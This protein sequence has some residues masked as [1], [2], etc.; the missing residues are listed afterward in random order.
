MYR[1][2]SS[3]FARG[4]VLTAF[5]LVS[6]A[7]P[8]QMR[9]EPVDEYRAN[10]EF[11]QLM[12][13]QNRPMASTDGRQAMSTMLSELMSSSN[14]NARNHAVGAVAP[15]VVQVPMKAFTRLWNRV[16]KQAAHATPKRQSPAV[17]LGES[18]YTG[19]ANPTTGILELT[20]RLGVTLSRPDQ[21]KAVPLVGEDVVL[22]RATVA[23]KPIPVSAAHGYQVWVTRQTGELIVELDILVPARGPRG[24]IE[25]DFRVVRTPV[26]SF[27][28]KFPTAGLEPRLDAAVR[29]S[30]ESHDQHTV[31]N[32]VVKPTTRIHLVGFRDL[33]D[34]QT[35]NA[36]VYADALNLLSVHENSLELFTVLGYTIL[37]AGTKEFSI[38]I[39][40][41][42]KVVSAGGRGA[43]QYTLEE[44]A[45]GTVLR[46][47]TAFPI[48]D[49]YEISLRL[50]QQLDK[51]ETID[52]DVPL[53]RSLG[54]EREVGWL[55]VEVP[56][57][58]RLEE[59]KRD[60]M[61]AIDTRQLP[62]ELVRSAVS[63]IL[64]AYR[65]H[66]AKDRLLRLSATR[67]P[68]KDTASESIDR[69]RAF[70]VISSEGDV[71][72]E[73]R[74]KLRNRLRHSIALA[75]HKDTRIRSVL[76]DGRPVKPSRDADGRLMLPL[77]R[78]SG[79]LA[80]L[81]QLTL[82]VIL[83]D[84]VEQLDW[85][86][87]PSL[88][89]PA[90][91]LPVSSLAWSVFVPTNN[92]YSALSSDIAPQ[93]YYGRAGWREPT[94]HSDSTNRN[95]AH[96][97][98]DRD[99]ARAASAYTGAMPVRIGL[100]KSGIRLEYERYWLAADQPANV[101]FTY[102]SRWLS[103]PLTFFLGLL[104]ML[105]CWLQQGSRITRVI[106]LVLL[107]APL[108]PLGKLAGFTAVLGFSLA[109]LAVY[110]FS[111]WWLPGAG[112]SASRW[113]RT[114]RSRFREA[115]ARDQAEFQAVLEANPDQRSFTRTARLRAITSRVLAAI[116]LAV[117]LAYL[118]GKIWALI[119]QLMHPVGG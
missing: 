105:G 34:S 83:E 2:E 87:T 1:R 117:A 22:A 44:R 35:G 42:V 106:G 67:L 94:S 47:E 11:D 71:L 64:E 62:P 49:S 80:Q 119:G 104:I 84:H 52:F 6:F 111:Q 43:F 51:R 110:L 57:K 82:S 50:E 115:R 73:M 90:I 39:P 108:W 109:G 60:D 92:L 21:W 76:L 45:D 48:R 114:L 58:T 93:S 61:L 16:R 24:S 7:S 17:V 91:D 15:A 10:A 41:G 77:E 20:V 38:H 30:V 85:L 103:Y 31:L 18:R 5:V 28:C 107:I 100:P 27:E 53:P 59:A 113:A 81:Q 25:Y 32:A 74:I 101:S 72:T 65:Y 95:V 70:T 88:S 75:I 13:P 8:G 29:A 23:G 68:E 102:I 33:G 3:W 19:H 66:D 12:E 56:G 118:L 4:T 26:T 36:R 79:S 37:Y 78:S 40:K 89:L 116:G 99:I 96:A 69:V 98:G 55:A 112:A 54:V 63:P 86:G 14:A 9:A 97:S 46:G